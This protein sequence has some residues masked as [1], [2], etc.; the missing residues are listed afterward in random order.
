MWRDRLVGEVL[1]IVHV[2]QEDEAALQAGHLDDWFGSLPPSGF[3]VDAV[4]ACGAT[5]VPLSRDGKV[6]G[7]YHRRS[8]DPWEDC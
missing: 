1:Q 4:C 2:F 5:K 3:P 6:V 8:W 7:V